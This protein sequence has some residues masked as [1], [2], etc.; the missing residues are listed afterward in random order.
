MVYGVQ[1][2]VLARVKRFISELLAGCAGIF[3][4]SWHLLGQWF[5]VSLILYRLF[6]EKTLEEKLKKKFFP[7]KY[8]SAPG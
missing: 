8:L 4:V 6:V 5:L 3:F 7:L 2:G 1:I